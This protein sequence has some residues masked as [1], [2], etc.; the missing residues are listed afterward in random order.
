VTQ[1]PDSVDPL[2]RQLIRA[3]IDRGGVVRLSA[4]DADYRLT[5]PD[6]RPQNFGDSR[7]V[8]REASLS[9]TGSHFIASRSTPTEPPVTV[10]VDTASRS[11]RVLVAADITALRARGFVPPERVRVLAADGKTPLYGTI[12]RPADFRPGQRYPVI[13]YVYTGG[14]ISHATPDFMN[15][16]GD[17]QQALADLGYIV[18]LLD[19]RMTAN[20]DYAFRWPAASERERDMLNDH[21]AG[22]RQ[23]AARYP[24]MDL[25]RLGVFGLS[26]GGGATVAALLNHPDVYKVGV[27]LGG[28]YDNRTLVPGPGEAQAGCAPPA[29]AC[30]N[31]LDFYTL[32]PLAGRLK[33]RLFLIA[34]D[35][36]EIVPL[37][38]TM[39]LVRA[40]IDADK[41]VDMFLIPNLGHL[42][43]MGSPY[44]AGL[45]QSYFLTHLPPTDA[46]AQG[47]QP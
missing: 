41:Q 40:F 15:L 1:W 12:H 42:E 30:E 36:D 27:A 23:L 22:L 19:G 38:V 32:A 34:S 43:I 18:I 28:S 47:K 31:G 46:G 2:H 21:V 16:F 20:R 37:T 13:E 5:G 10:L 9:P 25:D 14:Q 11:E 24:E 8:S 35:V 45:I 26:A 4:A 7:L 33:G 17:H 3:D 39:Q 44:V 6:P 29:A